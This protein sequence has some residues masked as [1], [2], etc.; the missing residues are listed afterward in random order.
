LD[1]SRSFSDDSQAQMTITREKQWS[2]Y[3]FNKSYVGIKVHYQYNQVKFRSKQCDA[4]IYLHYLNDSDEVVLFREINERDHGNSD[5]W[6]NFPGEAKKNIEASFDL[7]LKLKKIYEI[8]PERNVK[9]IYNQLNNYLTQLYKKSL[10]LL[11]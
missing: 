8:L 2:R 10:I 7:R 5:A 9:I 6:K 11:L 4:A 1:E 3:Y